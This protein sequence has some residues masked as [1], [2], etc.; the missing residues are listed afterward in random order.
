MKRLTFIYNDGTMAKWS[1]E[2]A[3]YGQESRNVILRDAN[4]ETFDDLKRPSGVPARRT[5]FALVPLTDVK[6][7]LEEQW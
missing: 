1:A 6:I 5:P 3:S 2:S 7:M 4:L